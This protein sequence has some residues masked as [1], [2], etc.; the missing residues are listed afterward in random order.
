MSYQSLQQSPPAATDYYD[1]RW[2]AENVSPKPPNPLRVSLVVEQVQQAVASRQQPNILDVGCGNGWILHALASAS[3][4]DWNLFGLEPST[5][6]VTNS[7]NRVPGA[8]VVQGYLGEQE[9]EHKLDAVICSEVIEHVPDQAE[10]VSCLAASLRDDGV[11]ILTTPNGRYRKGYF[12]AT[13]TQ[14]QPIENWPTSSGLFGLL[15]EHF[16]KI[17]LTTFDLTYWHQ[18][19]PFV[20]GFLKTANRIKGGW[21]VAFQC[22]SALEGWGHRGLYLL[23]TANRK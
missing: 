7:M 14:A 3:P 23:A 8:Q 22:E 5:I 11:L 12:E 13:N 16:T 6:G 19:H 17:R 9:F 21:R 10:F 4:G 20:S 1:Q 18:T 2:Q 15:S